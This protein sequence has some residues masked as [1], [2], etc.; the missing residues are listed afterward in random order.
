MLYR[1]SDLLLAP[2]DPDSHGGIELQNAAQDH[3]ANKGINR[4]FVE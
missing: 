1:T 3:T 2:G 4:T